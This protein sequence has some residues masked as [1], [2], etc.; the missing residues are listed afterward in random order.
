MANMILRKMTWRSWM[1]FAILMY[2]VFGAIF[3]AHGQDVDPFKAQR[4]CLNEA[5]KIVYQGASVRNHYDSK[6]NT[7]W[8]WEQTR[9]TDGLARTSIL[10]NNA[11]E[12]QTNAIF[13]GPEYWP[14][15]K[16]VDTCMVDDVQCSTLEEF[17][18]LVKQ[19]YPGL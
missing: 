3:L 16:G 13:I 18:K 4:A 7:C 8:I 11:F 9:L 10:V 15:K 19:H 17:N 2:L 6:S 12:V 1:V 14:I 5:T